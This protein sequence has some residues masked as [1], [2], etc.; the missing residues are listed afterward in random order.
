MKTAS[1]LRL[2][3]LILVAAFL[4]FASASAHRPSAGCHSHHGAAVCHKS[5]HVKVK[6]CKCCGRTY[7]VV[8]RPCKAKA[9][10][11]KHHHTHRVVAAKV[12]RRGHK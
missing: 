1:S 7:A 2:S 5:H 4:S 12:Y 9:K 8:V 11:V 10:P 6:K 3:I